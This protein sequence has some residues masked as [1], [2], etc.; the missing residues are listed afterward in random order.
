MNASTG[1]A[2]PDEIPRLGEL[3]TVLFAQEREFHSDPARQETG[4]RQIVA[5]PEVGA[6]LVLREAGRVVG[7]VN[8]LW[9]VSTFLGGKAAWLEDLVVDPAYRG[10]GG[11]ALLLEAAAAHAQAA[12]CSRI[13]LLTD[14]DN[15]RAKT[16]Y[17]RHGFAD[18]PMVPLRRML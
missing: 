11:G 9:T 8:L 18:S 12:G 3:L 10:R 14:N 6:I 4:L 17:R 7:M 1:L 16:L 13:T 5:H 2:T 15:E